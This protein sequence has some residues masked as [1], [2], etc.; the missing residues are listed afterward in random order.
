M[1]SAR[2]QFAVDEDTSSDLSVSSYNKAK[3]VFF[4]NL[5]TL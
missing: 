2:M 3:T 5:I 4:L 1:Q